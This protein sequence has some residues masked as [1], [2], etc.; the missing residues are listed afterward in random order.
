MEQYSS[1]LWFPKGIVNEFT[2]NEK[3]GPFNH[4]NIHTEFGTIDM[5]DVS[6]LNDIDTFNQLISDLYD[7]EDFE[8]WGDFNS[9][10]KFEKIETHE[11]K[12]G[13]KIKLSSSEKSL[14]GIFHNLPINSWRRKWS[15]LETSSHFLI[16]TGGIQWKGLDVMVFRHSVKSSPFEWNT[17]S[18]SIFSE[19]GGILG[20]FH[21]LMLET[22]APRMEKEW[23]LRLKRLET[24]S[25][26]GT[27]W[28][29]PHSRN[30][31]S[32][33]SLGDLTCKDWLN[34]DDNISLDLLNIGFQTFGMLITETTRFSCLRDIASMY[35]DIDNSKLVSGTNSREYLRK[36]F[37]ESWC[38]EAPQKWYSN[39]A[40]DGNLGG[41]QIWRYDVELKNLF[42]AKSRNKVYGKA[43]IKNVKNIQRALFNYR[44]I[45]GSALGMLLSSATIALLWPG[46]LMT[47]KVLILS[48]GVIIYYLGMKAYRNTS[49]PPY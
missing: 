26:S 16:P 17:E 3:L 11:T 21:T 23:N 42:V 12:K 7:L 38:K 46:L 45:S 39:S 30:T 41:M 32:I 15:E 5:L 28:R 9:L 13:I 48:I 25:S 44:I 1:K 2:E 8:F 6:E 22:S 19:M 43:W 47:S 31:N 10:D 4:Y 14:E 29:V 40:L 24:I 34:I 37:F 49:L 27:L 18:P 20:K 35:V 36:V 33:R